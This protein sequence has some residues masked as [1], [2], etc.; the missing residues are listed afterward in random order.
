M[1]KM[2]LTFV[3]F[4]MTIILTACQFGSV[5]EDKVITVYTERH[6][7][8]DQLLY[9][10]FTELTGIGVNLV[11]D[12]ADQLITRMSNEG[13]DSPADVLIIADAGRL[14]R[15]KEMDLLQPVTSDVLEEQVPS[16]YKD[17]NHYWYGLTMRARVLVYHP[18]R[19]NAS[20]LSTYE[21][22]TDSKWEGRI[23]TR[24]STNIYNQSLMSSMIEIM[25]EQ[26]A[27][28][29]AAGLVQ[30]FARDP[31]GNDRDQAKAVVSGEADIAIMNTYYIGRM[32]NSSD[33]YEVEVGE[34]VRI[35]F[36]N[37]D[38][39][40]THINVSGAGVA[41]H[42]KNIDEAIELIEFLTSEEAQRSYADANYEYPINPTVEPHDLLKSW[43]SFISQDIP[44]NKL[45]EHS[46]LATIIMNEEGWK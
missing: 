29:W 22:L 21:D 9:D 46:A 8:T 26:Q 20:E 4:L 13:Q 42:S 10:R 12:G 31:Q 7:D 15:A 17:T 3:M 39:T 43:G 38:T 1:R 36:P 24:T 27:R 11:S 35:F 2:I 37:Q 41:K 6:Y 28:A 33:P 16:K 40:G 18:D 5:G 25:G 44:L 32:L 23:V 19:V 30:N 34:T 45:G 14:H